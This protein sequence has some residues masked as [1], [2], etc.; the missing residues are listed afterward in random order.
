M[1]RQRAVWVAA[2]LVGAGAVLVAQK[3]TSPVELDRAMKTIGSAL[4]G[5]KQSIAS[6]AYVEAKVPLA[7]SRQTL[8]STRPFWDANQQPD[9]SKMTRSA[10][11]TLDALDKALSASAVDASAV[12][13]AV[14]AVTRA[15]DACHATAREG[16]QQTGFR[17]KSAPPR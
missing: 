12:G 8:A 7:L 13:A 4:D 5:V 6:K 3:V 1:T 10:V 16:D 15:C 14:D 9:V 17:I 11:A 2:W